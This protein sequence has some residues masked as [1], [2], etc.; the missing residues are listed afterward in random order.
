M[1]GPPCAGKSHL[2]STLPPHIKILNIDDTITQ[3]AHSEGF[4]LNQ[5]DSTPEDRSKYGKAM[6]RA[7]KQLRDTLLPQTIQ[8]KESFILDG[9]ASSIT[10]TMDLWYVL[11]E[12]GYDVIM[13][14]VNTDLDTILARN[15]NRERRLPQSVL[16]RAWHSATTNHKEYKQL[17]GDK[18]I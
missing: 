7:T 6:K 15:A 18:V 16:E 13:I 14:Y 3:L 9:C 1:A 2:L 12:N 10:Q 4:S 8:A 17:I 5:Q 11:E